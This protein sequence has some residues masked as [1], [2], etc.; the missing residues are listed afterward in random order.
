VC[1]TT[2]TTPED[3]QRRD[4]NLVGGDVGGGSTA[5]DQQLVFRPAP[6]WP[7]YRTPIRGLWLC[8]AAAHPGG[9][10]HGLVGWHA[11]RAVLRAGRTGRG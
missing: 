6:G 1:G 7:S 2:L 8:S 4:P 3:L 5:P 9:G 10:A 11:A